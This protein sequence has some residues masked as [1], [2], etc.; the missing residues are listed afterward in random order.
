M[1]SS[2]KEIN[3]MT[4]NK[5]CFIDQWKIKRRKRGVE[6][7]AILILCLGRGLQCFDS[8]QIGQERSLVTSKQVTKNSLK[9]QEFIA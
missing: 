9:C 7:T 5:I 3:G 6:I 8:S 1:S 4:V 2:S